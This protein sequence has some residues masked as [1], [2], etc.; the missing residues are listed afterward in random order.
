MEQIH[1]A[2]L[3]HACSHPEPWCSQWGTGDAGL[4]IRS[5]RP[6]T[7][8]FWGWTVQSTPAL[9]NA[10]RTPHVHSP[11]SGSHRPASH[12]RLTFQ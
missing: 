1:S 4:D 11:W 5:F 10:Q 6:L 2:S 8:V 7:F 9:L 12:L 3:P